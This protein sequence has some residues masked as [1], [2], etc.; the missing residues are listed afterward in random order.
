MEKCS[1][2]QKIDINMETIDDTSEIYN[3][4]ENDSDIESEYSSSNRS[5]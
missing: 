2:L 3:N 1:D 4:F 5:K